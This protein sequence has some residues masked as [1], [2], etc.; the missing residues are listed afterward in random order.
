MVPSQVSGARRRLPPSDVD[1]QALLSLPT[2]TS[3]PVSHMHPRGPMTIQ[4]TTMTQQP[5]T[6]EVSAEMYNKVLWELH[7][8]WVATN[9]PSLPLCLYMDF[10]NLT[11]PVSIYG[12]CQISVPT[13]YID[14]ITSP[15][16]PQYQSLIHRQ[17]N[18]YHFSDVGTLGHC[19]IWAPVAGEPRFTVDPEATL[20]IACQEERDATPIPT[21]QQPFIAQQPN[22][23]ELVYE[24][25]A[26]T[27]PEA[28]RGACR[29]QAEHAKLLSQVAYEA[30]HF[31]PP[32]VEVTTT[33]DETN[34]ATPRPPC[35]VNGTSDEE[36]ATTPRPRASTNDGAPTE[37]PPLP[38]IPAPELNI[39]EMVAKAC[40]VSAPETNNKTK[41]ETTELAAFTVEQGLNVSLHFYSC[42]QSPEL[43]H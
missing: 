22:I 42:H 29:R 23:S 10:C 21:P 13:V 38:P 2:T 1:R 11:W 8:E 31:V 34:H 9:V 39:D 18:G 26:E 36:V 40:D 28:A 6:I 33:S 41:T 16:G 3:T 12:R 30:R 4:L 14:H 24:T 5:R 35:V 17:P 32:P 19:S 15:P 7:R 25:L 20:R 27:F 43:E 37:T